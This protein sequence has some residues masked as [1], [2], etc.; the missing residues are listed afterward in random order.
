MRPSILLLAPALALLATTSGCSRRGA[1]AGAVFAYEVAATAESL[2]NPQRE[3]TTD[4]DPPVDDGERSTAG[5]VR[6]IPPHVP[7]SAADRRVDRPHVGFDLGGAY[8]AIEQADLEPCNAQGLAAGYGRVIVAFE[9]DGAVV[10]VAI[11]LPPGSAPTAQA[12]VEQAF[13]AVRVAPFEG[14][15]VNVRRAFFV[16]D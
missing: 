11:A 7:A 12:C 13:R 5:L 3:W 10:G 2:E 1:V 9:P 8:G 4:D 16:K 6:P 15:P 14:A